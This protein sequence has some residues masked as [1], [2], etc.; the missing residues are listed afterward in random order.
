[1]SREDSSEYEQEFDKWKWGW[2]K[3]LLCCNSEPKSDVTIQGS[4]MYT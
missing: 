2:A 4:L 3:T 1:M